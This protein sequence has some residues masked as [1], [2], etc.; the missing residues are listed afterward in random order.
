MGRKLYTSG[1]SEQGSLFLCLSRIST[2]GSLN[3]LHSDLLGFQRHKL[4]DDIRR[5]SQ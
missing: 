2:F 3:A 5:M 4:H 1:N